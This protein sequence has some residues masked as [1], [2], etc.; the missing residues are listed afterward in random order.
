M[1]RIPGASLRSHEVISG[2]AWKN[3]APKIAPW[4][5]EK[6]PTTIMIA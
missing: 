3:S 4:M 1:S 6:P 5:L 2:M